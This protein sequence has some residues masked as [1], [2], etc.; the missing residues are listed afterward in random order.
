MAKRQY[1]FDVQQAIMN[2]KEIEK[3]K[4]KKWKQLE[5][6]EKLK[7]RSSERDLYGT[8]LSDFQ[9]LLK[10]PA[11]EEVARLVQYA[12]KNASD[13]YRNALKRRFSMRV[14]WDTP[15]KFKQAP[16]LVDR[17]HINSTTYERMK[18]DIFV[19]GILEPILVSD[20]WEV[21]DGWQRCKIALE[22]ELESIPYVVI[23]LKTLGESLSQRLI[24][25]LALSKNIHRRQLSIEEKAYIHRQLGQLHKKRPLRGRPT[26]E[27]IEI[28]NEI[29][30]IGLENM[31]ETHRYIAHSFG[32]V[33]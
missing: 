26:R 28:S 25:D 18:K 24:L 20:S 16:I 19:R 9:P 29:K 17:I 7:D 11:D 30:E 32:L 23:N 33:K 2:E 13:C 31:S 21:I 15:T 5:L 12:F 1:H 4:G 14:Q 8:L 3:R 10:N 27:E 22:L 6:L